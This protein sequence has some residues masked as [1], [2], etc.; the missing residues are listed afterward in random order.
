MVVET[1]NVCFL[2]TILDRVCGR[3]SVS[4]LPNAVIT[5]C[6]PQMLPR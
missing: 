2:E 5:T 3:L 6:I 1:T 4:I